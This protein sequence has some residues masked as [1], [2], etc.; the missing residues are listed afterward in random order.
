[1]DTLGIEPIH[2]LCKRDALPSGSGPLFKNH[3]QVATLTDDYIAETIT[4]LKLIEFS[5]RFELRMPELQSGSLPL[6]D[7]NI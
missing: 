6:A 7:E 5:L 4:V 1:M 2:S 3:P